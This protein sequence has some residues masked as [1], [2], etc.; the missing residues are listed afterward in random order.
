MSLL[1]LLP[2][3]EGDEATVCDREGEQILNR[4]DE[5][6]LLYVQDYGQNADSDA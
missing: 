3:P 2:E 6:E 4:D 1:W 5:G